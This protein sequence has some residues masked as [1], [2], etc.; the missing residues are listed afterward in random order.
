MDTNIF[1]NMEKFDLSLVHRYPILLLTIF[2]RSCGFT[3]NIIK[4]MLRQ[5]SIEIMYIAT[6]YFPLE[7]YQSIVLLPRRLGCS[8]SSLPRSGVSSSVWTTSQIGA[9]DRLATGISSK[10]TFDPDD[11]STSSFD[12]DTTKAW[13]AQNL[14]YSTGV[15]GL[16]WRSTK[17]GIIE[18]RQDG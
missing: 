8:S 6:K 3:S 16:C 12:T 15:R 2:S 1:G 13:R 5:T 10:N 4:I 11:Q 18:W 7:H 14:H 9:Y 17:R